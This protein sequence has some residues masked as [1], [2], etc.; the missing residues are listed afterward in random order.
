MLNA[1]V[2]GCGLIGSRWSHP[3]GARPGATHAG[4]YAVSPHTRLVAV[5][6]SNEHAAAEAARRWGLPRY[7]TDARALLEAERPEIIS[8][9]TGNESHAETIGAVLDYG[10]TRAILAEKPLALDVEEGAHIAERARDQGVSLAVNY[11]RRYLP[12]HEDVATRIRDGVIGRVERVAG[13]YTKGVI[14]NGS[15]WF[16]T[17]EWLVGRIE[18]VQGFETSRSPER[19]RPIDVRLGI[20]GSVTGFLQSCPATAGAIFEIDLLGESGRLVIEESGHQ[21]S[22]WRADAAS[23][24]LTLVERR[25]LPVGDPVLAAIEDLALATQESRPP[26][27]TAVN[28]VR[29]L[30][31]ASEA[32]TS[33]TSGTLR[34]VRS[35]PALTRHE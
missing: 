13:R 20:S 5:C 34:D 28:A 22:C 17:I 29:A 30:F 25:A 23:G 10:C 35:T 32:L 6:D 26:K 31:V 15:H 8:V 11:T 21:V 9:C 24:R 16:D 7:Y 3:H 1:A 2:I 12:G 14:H 19:D 33:A 27:C 4:A 18:T